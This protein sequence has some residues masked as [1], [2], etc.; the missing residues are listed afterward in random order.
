M[1]QIAT[2][3]EQSKR[4]LAAGLDP[5][6]ADMM[7]RNVTLTYDFGHAMEVAT[8]E[9]I[10][11]AF[12]AKSEDSIPAW[13]LSKLWDICNDSGI[14]PFNFGG[15]DIDSSS[16][17]EKLVHWIILGVH[18]HEVLDEYLTAETIQELNRDYANH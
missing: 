16:L 2:T 17:I 8:A 15:D 4:L 6:S 9:P 7:W 5:E 13:S 11:Y 1:S 14:G 3:V 12:N 10:L 18:D